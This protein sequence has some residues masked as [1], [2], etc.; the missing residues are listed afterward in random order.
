MADNAPAP[1]PAPAPAESR[2]T[3]MKRLV[4][5]PKA[6][7]LFAG[8]LLLGAGGVVAWR[9][10]VL[11]PVRAIAEKRR[12]AHEALIRL[13]DLQM[14]HHRRRGTFANDLETLLAGSPDAQKIRDLIKA[15][16]DPNTLTVVGDADSFKLEANVLDP[17]RTIIKFR[18]PF[19]D[20]PRALRPA[21]PDLPEPIRT[22]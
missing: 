13:Y 5:Q 10:V 21:A 18:G 2:L 9:Q 6:L 7:G 14:A 4:S 8:L 1:E 22:P 20:K 17:Q 12:G 11:K 19:P 16:S 15:N 3:H